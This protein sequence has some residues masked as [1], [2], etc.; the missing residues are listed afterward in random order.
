M[1]GYLM[2]CIE[3]TAYKQDM[4]KVRNTRLYLEYKKY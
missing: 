1:G 4:E 3:Y 2:R